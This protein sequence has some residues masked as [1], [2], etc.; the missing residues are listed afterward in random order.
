MGVLMM[1]FGELNQK[2]IER[3]VYCP[4]CEKNEA[5][6]ISET[7]NVTDTIQLPEVGCQNALLMCMTGGCWALVKGYPLIEKKK[8]Y[9]YRTYGFC[10]H[11]GNTYAA[12]T[13]ESK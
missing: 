8:K 6:L 5:F 9:S 10:P 1:S 12:G 3:D 11:C 7:V 2:I 13:S 4:F